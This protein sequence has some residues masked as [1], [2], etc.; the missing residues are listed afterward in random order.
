MEPG[1][2]RPAVWPGHLELCRDTKVQTKLA[3]ARKTDGLEPSPFAK[4]Q[5]KTDMLAENYSK[6]SQSYCRFPIIRFVISA[7]PLKKDLP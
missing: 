5:P 1:A 4:R 7:S 6:L 2:A 3:R